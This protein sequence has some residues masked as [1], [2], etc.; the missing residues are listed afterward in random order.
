ML[1]RPP[2]HLRAPRS[3]FQSPRA[4]A[5]RPSL[6]KKIRLGGNTTEHGPSA[7]MAVCNTSRG[8]SATPLFT[9]NFWRRS[10]VRMCSREFLGALGLHTICSWPP[11]LPP[12]KGRKKKIG[13]THARVR[14]RCPPLPLHQLHLSQTSKNTTTMV[15]SAESGAGSLPGSQSGGDPK[16]R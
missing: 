16:S 4:G 12:H 15:K 7:V 10:V 8:H 5:L 3:M 9:G 14:A 1:L 11:P 6:H 2:T 13:G